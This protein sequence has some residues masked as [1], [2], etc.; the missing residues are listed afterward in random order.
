[1]SFIKYLQK[2]KTSGT[3]SVPGSYSSLTSMTAIPK[4]VVSPTDIRLIG[5]RL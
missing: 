5:V 3:D 2:L 1:M 4:A